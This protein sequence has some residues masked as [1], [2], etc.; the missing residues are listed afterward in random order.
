MYL[1]GQLRPQFIEAIQAAAWNHWFWIA[2]ALPFVIVIPFSYFKWGGCLIAPVAFI[3]SW[4]M[5]A[6]AI[7]VYDKSFELNALTDS[8]WGAVTA[9]FL[10]WPIGKWLRKS[11][12]PL[13]ESEL[14]TNPKL[15]FRTYHKSENPYEPPASEP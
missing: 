5:Y 11:R 2:Y 4:C 1:L 12:Y 15:T 10:T 9:C 14:G 13:R 6:Y 7:Y 3:A 8:E